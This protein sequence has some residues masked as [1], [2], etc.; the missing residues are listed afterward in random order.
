MLLPPPPSHCPKILFAAC[1][2]CFYMQTLLRAI[3]SLLSIPTRIGWC[4]LKVIRAAAFLGKKAG[5]FPLG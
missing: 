2:S 3:Q 4:D 1:S 5:G